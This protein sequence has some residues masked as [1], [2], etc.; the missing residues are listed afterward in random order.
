MDNSKGIERIF[1]SI[2]FPGFGQIL[3]GHLV[4]AI[5]FIAAELVINVQSNLNRVIIS[6]FY[7][8]ISSAIQQT[9]YQW[10]M[11]YPCVYTFAAWDAFKNS[12]QSKRRYMFLPFVF[13]AFLGTIGVIYSPTAIGG[14]LLGPVWLP[15]MCLIFGTAIGC[16]IMRKAH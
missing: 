11:F 13:A 4:K 10:L 2:A 14:V 1:W 16:F 9:N 15:I 6:S 7:W 12:S 8:D 5:L 3:N